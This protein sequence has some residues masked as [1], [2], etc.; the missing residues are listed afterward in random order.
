MNPAFK[1]MKNSLGWRQQQM[2]SFCRKYPGLHSIA[3]D[4]KTQQVA[5]SLAK[6]GL[7]CITNIATTGK[8]VYMVSST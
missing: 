1:T 2:L 4:Q 3:T 5:I 8:P 7:L 6:R